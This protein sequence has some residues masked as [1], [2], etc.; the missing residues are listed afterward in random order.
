MKYRS[1]SNST[2][3]HNRRFTY[4]LTWTVSNNNQRIHNKA[5]MKAPNRRAKAKTQVS[6]IS[7]TNGNFQATQLATNSSNSKSTI[8]NSNLIR[9][10]VPI[11]TI[12]RCSNNNSKSWGSLSRTQ[13]VIVLA[14]L[15][16]YHSQARV[17]GL[18]IIRNRILR[19]CTWSK[20]RPCPLVV[21]SV[22]M[23]LWTSSKSNSYKNNKC[24]YP[25]QFINPTTRHKMGRTFRGRV[26]TLKEALIKLH[27]LLHQGLSLIWWIFK[28]WLWSTLTKTLKQTKACQ[29]HNINLNITHPLIADPQ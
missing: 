26:S 6:A 24:Q 29:L 12:C 3:T 18:Y 17:K 21:A 19:T 16:T 28:T 7:S 4:P 1:S 27:N 13:T 10:L 15:L 8:N 11:S 14:L 20:C 22:G 2:V 23:P 5:F 25:H 9:V